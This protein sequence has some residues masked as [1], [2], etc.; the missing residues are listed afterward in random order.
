MGTVGITLAG[1][2]NGLVTREMEQFSWWKAAV[3]GLAT[4]FWPLILSTFLLR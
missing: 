2:Y 3:V 4:L 1:V